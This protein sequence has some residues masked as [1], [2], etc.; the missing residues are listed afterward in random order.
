MAVEIA[1]ARGLPSAFQILCGCDGNDGELADLARDEAR[2]RKGAISNGEVDTFFDEIARPLGDQHLDDDLGIERAA[3]RKFRHDM[4]AREAGRGGD[5]HHARR[6]GLS[7]TDAGFRCF[8][9][10]DESHGRFVK[11]A[12]GLGQ[13]QTAGGAHKKLR[14]EMFFERCDLLADRRLPCPKLARNRRKAPTFDAAREYLVPFEPVHPI[15][16]REVGYHTEEWIV[17]DPGLIYS[18]IGGGRRRWYAT[19]TIAAASSAPE[20]GCDA[21][22][23]PRRPPVMLSRQLGR[24]H[25]AA[26]APQGRRN[27][28]RRLARPPMNTIPP[29]A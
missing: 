14:T 3:R 9:I 11:V 16:L 18:G 12:P 1:E 21:S 13:A 6:R 20:V 8:E 7:R 15:L 10:A 5:A 17:H 22:P 23:A 24:I 4:A 26:C 19:S 28:H 27:V 25:S 2:V 29:T